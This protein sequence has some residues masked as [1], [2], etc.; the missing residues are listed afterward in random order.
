MPKCN[1]NK[2]ALLRH[3]CSPVKLLH[4]FRIFLRTP[5][6]G[7]FLNLVTWK[8]IIVYLTKKF[9]IFAQYYWAKSIVTNILLKKFSFITI[10]DAQLMV[11]ITT[12]KESPFQSLSFDSN[13]IDF[14]YLNSLVS[15]LKICWKF[16]HL[17]TFWWCLKWQTDSIM[18]NERDTIPLAY[19]KDETQYQIFKTQY[20][21]PYLS[22]ILMKFQFQYILL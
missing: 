4:I 20:S 1:F 11:N 5:L 16:F 7:C 19:V 14:R 6:D 22:K 10:P 13:K 8:S 18:L 17:A 12:D 2:V 3:G 21:I 9:K 15:V